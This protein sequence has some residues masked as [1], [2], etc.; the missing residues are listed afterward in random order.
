[1]SGMV[2]LVI[3][4]GVII[5]GTG[6]E[7]FEADVAIAAGRIV[8]LG[9]VAARG[10]EEI[11]AR[12]LAVTPG[13]VDIHT[14][15]DGQVTWEN[16][17]VPSSSH[18]VTSVVMGNCG[19]GFAPCRRQ[20]RDTLI[21]LMEGVEDIPHP[22]L[23]E[24]VPWQWETFPQYLD[25]LA[26]RHYDMDICGYV[27]HSALR[28][29]AM[30]ERGANGEPASAAER[31]EMA[32]LVRDAV[33]AGAMG[34]STSRTFFH[35]S[36]DGKS[37]PTFRAAE[38]E[39][40]AMALALKDAG[41]G[42]MQL[43][44]DFDGDAEAAFAC[45]RRMVQ[46]SGR[47]LSFS[48]MEG[49]TGPLS[50]RWPEIL[51]WVGR[52]IEAGL[53]IKAQVAGRAVGMLLGHELTLNPFYAT[54]AYRELAKLP[55]R[56]RIVQLRRSGLRARIL[57]EPVD[58]DP[59]NVL[60]WMV[61]DFERMFVLG[62][63]PN[64]EPLPQTSIA[65]QARRRGMAPE[66]LAYELMLERDGQAMLYYALANYANGSLD[67]CLEMMRHRGSVLG[68]GDGGAHCG[69]ICDG[70]LP[71]FMLTHWARDR[72]RGE[73]LPLPWIVKALSREAALAVG[74]ADRGLIAPGYKAD[75]NVLDM[76]RLS[77]KAPE[78]AYDLPAGGRRLV[79]RAEG[80]RATIVSGTVVYRDG[81]ATG[82]LPG[83]LV[84]G[85]QPRPERRPDRPYGRRTVAVH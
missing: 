24:G 28:V 67:S 11:D 14:H 43:I 47:P 36:S 9:T 46:T 48:L 71:T 51:D 60:G 81:E 23:A 78:V 44:L 18:G 85:P 73:R 3:R 16:R 6:T 45:M 30:G 66:A 35:R 75:V 54:E 76:G 2:D 56:E 62:D 25:F 20:E 39:L 79:Q 53:P 22:V 31:A 69:T 74:L 4:N 7:P 61:R 72:S 52:A 65:A 15:Y 37:T 29:Y 12:G 59:A 77:L 17:L 64:Y 38:D 27:P 40:M 58:R 26:G 50:P 19:V 33:A 57:S 41:E 82:R 83:R 68:L 13:F 21:R 80:Y 55:L 70:S 84:R 8:E 32:R 49:N 5:D 63:P 34:F 10:R 42:A 1:M